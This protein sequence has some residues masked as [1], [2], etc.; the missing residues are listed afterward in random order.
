M[1]NVTLTSETT[2]SFVSA[3]ENFTRICKTYR[4][5]DRHFE[6][7]DS[8]RTNLTQINITLSLL[9]TTN[10]NND[11]LNYNITKTRQYTAVSEER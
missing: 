3:K 1:K 9:S 5:D 4:T 11:F 7:Q 10:A 8:D 6:N 2:T